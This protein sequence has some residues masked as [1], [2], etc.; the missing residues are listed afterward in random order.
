MRAALRAQINI[1]TASSTLGHL[2]PIIE[3]FRS[4]EVLIGWCQEKG[5]LVGILL[6]TINDM[7]QQLDLP[8]DDVRKAVR[9]L[10]LYRGVPLVGS[11]EPDALTLRVI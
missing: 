4:L 6:V 7:E 5:F 11:L 3:D 1:I 9:Q 2:N 8:E 10:A